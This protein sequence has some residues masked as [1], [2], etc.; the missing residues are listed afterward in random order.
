ML[1]A[2]LRRGVAVREPVPKPPGRLTRTVDRV[3]DVAEFFT[4]DHT[5]EGFVPPRYCWPPSVS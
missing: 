3:A 1:H 5:E 2:Y 4:M